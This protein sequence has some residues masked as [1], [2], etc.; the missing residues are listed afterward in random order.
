METSVVGVMKMGNIEPR[1]GVEPASLAF[2][3]SVFTI[4]PPRLPDFNT[5]PMRTCLCYFMRQRSVQ[6]TTIF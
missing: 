1:A 6:T 4:T 2:R 3:A 5:A